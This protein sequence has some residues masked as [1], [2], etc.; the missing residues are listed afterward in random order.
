MQ[1]KK[2]TAKILEN[3][4][5]NIANFVYLWKTQMYHDPLT[6]RTH[7]NSPHVTMQLIVMMHDSS[8]F[9]IEWLNVN[10]GDKSGSWN[11]TSGTLEWVRLISQARKMITDYHHPKMKLLKFIP[12]KLKPLRPF[13]SA[14]IHENTVRLQHSGH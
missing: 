12:T 6:I 2:E 14:V 4:V 13:H 10:A 1:I 3:K 11:V 7:W 5:G 8:H 9:V